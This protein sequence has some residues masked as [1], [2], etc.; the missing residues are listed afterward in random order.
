MELLK[1]NPNLD[2]AD[3]AAIDAAMA[4]LP[5]RKLPIAE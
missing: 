1:L 4:A 3:H 5:A 2:P